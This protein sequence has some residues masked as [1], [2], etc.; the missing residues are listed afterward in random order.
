[1]RLF[2]MHGKP[3]AEVTTRAPVKMHLYSKALAFAQNKT[4]RLMQED[5]AR[6]FLAEKPWEKGLNWRPT[7]GMTQTL[8]NAVGQKVATGWM[9]V[10]LRLP[11][12]LALELERLTVTQNATLSSVLYTMLYWYTWFVYPPAHE[13]KRRE[14]FRQK[15]MQRSDQ[16]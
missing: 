6:Q 9:Q 11:Q 10:N 13:V 1:M 2:T 12:D 5:M 14:E 16:S 7:Q 4:L 3:Y 15:Q 8:S